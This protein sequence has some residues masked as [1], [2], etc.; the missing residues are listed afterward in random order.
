TFT[1]K[2]GEQVTLRPEGTAGVARALISNGLSQH[3]PLKYFYAG[4]MFRYERPQKGRLRQFHQIGVELLGVPG[5]QADV[6]VLALGQHILDGLGVWDRTT[7]EL[8]TLG[9]PESR[10][11]YRKVLVA[12]FQ[13]HLDR[14]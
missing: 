4:P 14:L 5:P 10:D 1:D 6:E 13:D 8:N 12:Y 3:L 2:G 9:D 7:L 11:A